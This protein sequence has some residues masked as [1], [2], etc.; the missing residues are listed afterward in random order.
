MEPP[1]KELP[2]WVDKTIQSEKRS[3]HRAVWTLAA[4]ALLVIVTALYL[5]KTFFSPHTLRVMVDLVCGILAAAL[6]AVAAF[7]ALSR[8]VSHSERLKNIE[9]RL[10]AL[11]GKLR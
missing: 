3:Y 8:S 11:E 7:A 10:T 9:R 1:E 4:T 6:A 5:M 2:D